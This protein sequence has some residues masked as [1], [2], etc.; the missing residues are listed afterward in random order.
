MEL[1]DI[2]AYLAVTVE[3]TIILCR[4]DPQGTCHEDSDLF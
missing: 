4:K 1:L 3:D 2:I